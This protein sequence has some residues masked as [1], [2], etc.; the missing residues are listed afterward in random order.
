MSGVKGRSPLTGRWVRMG[1]V[2]PPLDLES[3]PFG[4]DPAM[5]PGEIEF[6]GS[7]F[8]ATRAPGQGFTVWDVGSYRVDGDEL[9]IN[10]ANDATGRYSV[11]VG[12]DEFTVTD[13]TGTTTT[14]RRMD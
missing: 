8:R 3:V 1:E 11:S 2:P 6:S 13:A 7:R 4:Q 5:L 9:S 14:Y 12:E 10:L